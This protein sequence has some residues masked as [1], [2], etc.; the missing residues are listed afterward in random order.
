MQLIY[1]HP[2]EAQHI[3]N[4][5]GPLGWLLIIYGLTMLALIVFKKSFAPAANFLFILFVIPAGIFYIFVAN[6][7]VPQ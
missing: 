7:P 2:E 3:V 6:W 4:A 1:P 5:L